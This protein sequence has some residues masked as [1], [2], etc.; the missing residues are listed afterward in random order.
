[1]RLKNISKPS[2]YIYIFYILL[3]QKENIARL[4][5]YDILQTKVNKIAPEGKESRC[6]QKNKKKQTKKKKIFLKGRIR[7]SF[8][9]N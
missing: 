6:R 7:L 1:M 4:T 9:K 8:S 3:F 2:K 5:I